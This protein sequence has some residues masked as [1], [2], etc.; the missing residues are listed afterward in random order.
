MHLEGSDF[1][2]SRIYKKKTIPTFRRH[3]LITGLY[4][5][6]LKKANRV[7]R[8]TI[9]DWTVTAKL[10]LHSLIIQIC[11]FK[12][13]P[14]AKESHLTVYKVLLTSAWKC[15]TGQGLKNI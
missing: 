8:L 2:L 13:V 6:R 12:E 9:L 4:S 11:Q 15:I 7:P 3:L 5:N 1:T 10:C 14:V